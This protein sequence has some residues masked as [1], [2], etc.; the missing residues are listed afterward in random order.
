MSIK[1]VTIGGRS[2]IKKVTIGGGTLFQKSSGGGAP[3]NQ[4]IPN[5]FFADT[6]YYQ[7]RHMTLDSVSDG[8]GTLTTTNNRTGTTFTW[9][10]RLW[11]YMDVTAG[12]V[13]YFGVSVLLATSASYTKMR[14]EK[15]ADLKSNELRFE[16][17]VQGQWLR[18]EGLL[19]MTETVAS[20]DLGR[21]DLSMN[22]NAAYSIG[23]TSYV[24]D[25]F[26]VDLT[27]MYG[28]GNEPTL[29]EF[30]AAYPLDAYPYAPL[31]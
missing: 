16:H 23:M 21:F 29:A 3:T 6:S 17:L 18:A 5:P 28:A 2:D 4:L 22:G 30:R 20:A 25:C 31:Q 12:H 8:V 27:E 7:W 26:C 15:G 19:T 10:M 14:Y 24:K 13:Y 11:A 1:A 9:G